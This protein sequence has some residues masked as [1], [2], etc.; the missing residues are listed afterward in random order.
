MGIEI[1]IGN[2]GASA[3]ASAASVDILVG[4]AT[5]DILIQSLLCGY[6][7]NQA[8]ARYMFPI[9]IPAGLRIAAQ[10]STERP[11]YLWNGSQYVSV[12]QMWVK[13][14]G[15]WLQPIAVWSKTDS[16]WR[17]VWDGDER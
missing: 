5:D 3:T 17:K 13:S 6:R 1:I 15:E 11:T 7:Y 16:G 10:A 2:T 4:G 9:H 14:V 12:Q 8:V